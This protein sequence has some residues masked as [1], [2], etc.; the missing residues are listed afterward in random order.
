M[1]NLRTP[2]LV[3]SLLCTL[4]TCAVG[5]TAMALD[6][7][8][9]DITLRGCPEGIDPRSVNPATAC[10]IPLD[11]P[12]AAGAI[13]GGDGQ[14]GMPM[15][16][17]PRLFNGTYRVNVP[18]GRLISL[19][20][21]EPTV[22]DA[23][24]AIGGDGTDAHGAP[25]ITLGSGQTAN[26]SLYYYYDAPSQAG[27]T[28]RLTFRGCPAGFDA[29]SDDFF[30]ECAIPLDAPDASIITWGGDGQGGME[31]TA[32][33][34]AWDG[35][36]VYTAGPDATSLQLQHLDPM[37]RTAFQVIGFDT[38]RGDVY[39]FDLEPGETREVFIFYYYG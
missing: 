24:L 13:W 18:A 37:V 27:T 39:T 17:V 26:I 28:L 19:Q 1:K 11:A 32:L 33:D 31:I 2:L 12:D 15:T 4:L 22:R 7:A 14:G 30:G 3:L 29:G 8:V 38:V 5:T 20:N 23:F 16:D 9:L 36:Y 35:T 6:G 25:V 21:F 34:R 10:T